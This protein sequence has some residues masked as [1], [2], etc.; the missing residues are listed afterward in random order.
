[1]SPC[2]NY[3]KEVSMAT[4]P[5]PSCGSVFVCRPGMSS[6][7]GIIKLLAALVVSLV[8]ISLVLAFV[9]FPQLYMPPQLGSFEELVLSKVN[10]MSVRSFAISLVT[11][12]LSAFPSLW[13]R[14]VLVDEERLVRGGYYW[15][16]AVRLSLLERISGN[17]ES[18]APV[19]F[20]VLD[21]ANFQ[22][23]KSGLS[24]SYYKEPSR[25]DVYSSAFEWAAPEEGTYYLVVYA[26]Y[27]SARVRLRVEVMSKPLVETFPSG[28]RDRDAWYIW[29]VNVWVAKNIHYVP[30]PN[31][32]LIQ[33]P[34]E[35]LR[36]RA[37]DCDDVAVLM[38]SM[39]NALGLRT[40]FALVDTNG[41]GRIDHI[42]V[43]VHYG[44][45]PK[46][47]LDSEKIIALTAGLISRLPDK[48]TI[49]YLEDRG[50][51][52]WI[53]ADPLFSESKYCVGMIKHEPYKILRTFPSN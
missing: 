45:T 18:S 17:V 20:Y 49:T 43:L 52:I 15:Y 34:E 8:F 22:R 36:L 4:S 19:D 2:S 42:A 6:K 13:D 9:F 27:G 47:F 12:P 38:A 24:F 25:M 16:V 48:Y 11:N 29:M 46:D 41:D 10:P 31:F 33:D 39:Y 32:E 44:G 1:M 26:K 51:G 5:R 37:G 14:H 21:E 28:I 3:G 23:F 30:D 35:T 50:G 40:K 7:G 53:I